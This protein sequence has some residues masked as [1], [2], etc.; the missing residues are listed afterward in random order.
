MEKEFRKIIEGV[1]QIKLSSREKE[2]MRES[3]RLFI[4]HNPVREEVDVR[5]Q[6]QQRSGLFPV[7]GSIF[8]AN[9]LRIRPMVIT[10]IV[11]IVVVLSGGA[12]LAAESALPGDL[13][14]NVKVEVNEKVRGGLAVSDEAKAR[15]AADLTGRRLQEAATLAAEGRLTAEAQAEIESRLNAHM[16]KFEARANKLVAK[17]KANAAAELSSNLEA[18]LKAHGQVIAIAGVK[19]E[20]EGKGETQIGIIHPL[21][22]TIEA[23]VGTVQK[24]RADAEAKVTGGAKADVRAAAE[25]KLKAATNKIAEVRGAIE[26][27]RGSV[28]ASTTIEAEA[29]LHLA[30]EAVLEGKTRLEADAFAE[31]FSSFERAHRLAQE[32]HL[33][34]MNFQKFNIDVRDNNGKYGS[35]PVPRPGA[36]NWVCPDSSLA[37]PACEDGHWLINKCPPLPVG[38]ASSSAAETKTETRGEGRFWFNFGF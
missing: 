5:P 22:I 3:L 38:L 30:E 16:E 10:V 31:A 27:T 28:S 19:A 11:A 36:P 23:K 34:L 6:L 25:G 20:S 1:R 35:C 17:G 33:V 21:L 8:Q 15:V 7:F 14:Y 24:T 4:E 26:R 13:L 12:S 32:A 37:G 2:K 29:R 9:Q 18:A